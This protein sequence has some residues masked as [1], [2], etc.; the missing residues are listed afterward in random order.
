MTP[1]IPGSTSWG[2]WVYNLKGIGSNVE[3]VY[4]VPIYGTRFA[5]ALS[6]TDWIR[7]VMW[8]GR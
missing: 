4:S 1:S 3:W 8:A 2:K 5:G 6:F 7:C